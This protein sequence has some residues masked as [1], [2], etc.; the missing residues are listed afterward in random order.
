MACRL[1]TCP[2]SRSPVF[3][4]PTTDGVVRPPS[5]FGMT[6]GSPP[7]M[8][9]TQELVV[10]RSIPIILAITGSFHFYKC[11]EFNVLTLALWNIMRIECDV[12]KFQ[13]R[14]GWGGMRARLAR[15]DEGVGQRVHQLRAAMI[16]RP[17]STSCGAL[18]RR[19][20]EGTRPYMIGH[21]EFTKR[22][23]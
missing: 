13:M 12:V 16:N 23:G 20:G 10:P 7:S 6:L 15:P 17:R 3:V 4:K 21:H 1:A 9:A 19:A 5:S 14:E 18:H 22:E 8:T 11:F 2:T